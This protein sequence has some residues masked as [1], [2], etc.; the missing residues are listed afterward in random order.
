MGAGKA[1]EKKRG[2]HTG[3]LLISSESEGRQSPGVGTGNCKL[4]KK[5]Q[6]TKKGSVGWCLIE[7][8]Y[9]FV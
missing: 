5:S 4:G 7:F 2:Q 6:N 1:R 8:L 9:L 3:P